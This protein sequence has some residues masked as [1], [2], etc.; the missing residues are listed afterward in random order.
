MNSK[1]FH[2]SSPYLSPSVLDFFD[3][4][5]HEKE[6]LKEM[7]LEWNERLSLSDMCGKWKKT[8]PTTH[9][10][11]LLF[12]VYN[13]EGL[14]TH[15][16]DMDILIRNYQPHLCIL[17]GVGAASRK[18]PYFPGY[19]GIAQPGSNAFGGV[20]IFHK[21]SLKCQ[22]VDR[23]TNFL[24]I[25][26]SIVDITIKIGAIYVPPASSPPTHLFT[27][28][29]D[30]FFVIF[31]DFNAKHRQW[32]CP[33]NNTSGNELYRWLEESG[34]EVIA[35]M[36]ATSRRSD[37]IID[38][39][40]THDSS[41]WKIEV[42]EEGTS[43]H[44]PILFQSPFAFGAE[45]YF[46]KTNWKLFTFF[47]TIV[48]EYWNA[49][50]YNFDMNSFFDLFSNFI[51]SLWD[52]CSM[53]EDVSRYRI[54]WPPSL[55]ILAKQVNRC[56]RKYRRTHKMSHLEN[57]LDIKKKFVY[58]RCRFL[59]ERRENQT[60]WM[61]ERQNIWKYVK[62]T[63][64][65]FSPPFHGLTSDKGT[66]IKNP[67]II[68]ESLADY[69]EKHFASPQHDMTNPSHLRSLYE[70]KEIENTP[71]LSLGAITYEEVMREWSKFRPKK[72]TDSMDTSA[73]L[74]KKLPLPYL[75]IFTVLFN[76]CAKEGGFFR[77]AKHAKV[78]CL[79]KE[80]LYPSV[81]KLRP[82]SLLP[83]IGKWFERI[84]HQRMINWCKEMNI[85]VDE[86]SGFTAGRRLQ[87]RILALVEDLRQSIAACNRPAL[88][89][90]VDFLS[91][92]D[93]LW[94]PALISNLKMLGMPL[95]LIKWTYNWLQERTITIHF[96]DAKS[97]TI[98]MFVGAPQGSVLA[99][100]LFRLHVHHLP[101]F[102]FS[103]V[104]HMF[105][106]DLA[107]HITGDLE[108]RFSLNIPVLEARAKFALNQLSKFANDNILPV[109][110][111]K[112]KAMLVH[113]VVAPPKPKIQYNGQEIEIV[114]KFKYLG[115]SISTKLGWGE[116][117][118]ERVRK[119]RKVYN[120]MRILYKKIPVSNIKT[121]KKLFSAFAMPHF[122]WIFP[123]W[124]TI[125]DKQQRYIEH[126]YVSGLRY[127][128]HLQKWD[129]TTTLILCR[130]KSLLD[131]LY[132]YWNRFYT[133]L[134]DA[135]DAL[136]LRQSHRAFEIVTADDPNW[137]KNLGFR[138]TNRFLNRLRA[139]S[140]HSLQEWCVFRDIHS[141]QVYEYRVN[142]TH[143][144][145]FM[146]KY[147]LC[148]FHT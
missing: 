102:F 72:S 12:L 84:V 80:G 33:K 134:V 14:N 5:A 109:N 57:F 121:R 74:L 34:M 110:I 32:N 92:F 130:E 48:F 115:V 26:T 77:S 41:K 126:V 94:Y 10:Q 62:P 73:F 124:F 88:V 148:R 6:S 101:S 9:T 69:Y 51:S 37:A 144:N 135:P 140:Q 81:K 146:Y 83:N 4:N 40:I 95:P 36:E 25:E 137:Y 108:K 35:P 68:V 118:N 125:T 76:K 27:K 53:Y 119:I 31:G 93:R 1:S 117:I 38:F 79:S 2:F 100:S 141:R 15:L 13:V 30:D 3:G 147:F 113:S 47:L 129:D 28:Y 104:S 131:H 90:F 44:R 63:F 98:P 75:S 82:I 23:E 18:L 19:T 132:T 114:D 128:Y 111:N 107:I 7:L 138:R 86:Q 103:L 70:Y 21:E 105:A 97:R 112:T 42:L 29:K 78:I 127:V 87:T 85:Y 59:D 145:L 71:D 43:D 120:G 91:A 133:H 123:L 66:I 22:V 55:V 8:R 89:I 39:G 116:Y 143:I 49:L 45:S 54:P 60:K 65:N 20:A 58:E 52:R 122:I 96:G 106:D 50:V 67:H 46:R 142:T 17:S 11:N 64:H 24:V 61:N 139:R 99:A 56:R 16:S 136:C